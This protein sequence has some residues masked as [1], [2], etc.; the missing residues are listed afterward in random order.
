LKE[1]K[2]IKNIINASEEHL[3]KTMG[4]KAEIVYKILNQAY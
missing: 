4:K 3:K 1:F 2:T